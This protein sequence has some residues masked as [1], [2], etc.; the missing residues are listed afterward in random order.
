MKIKSAERLLSA[1]KTKTPT[2][3]VINNN[4]VQIKT[5]KPTKVYKAN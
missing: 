4:G 5:Q 1:M 2:K 3:Y